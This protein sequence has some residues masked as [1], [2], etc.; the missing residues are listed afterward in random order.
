[1]FKYTATIY[2]GESEINSHSGNDLELLFIWALSEVQG[3]PGDLNG[4]II[5]NITYLVERAFRASSYE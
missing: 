2:F 4:K 5:N 1:M 3:K